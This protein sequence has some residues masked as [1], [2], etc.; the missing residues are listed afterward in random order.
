MLYLDQV[1]LSD[2]ILNNINEFL[3]YFNLNNIDIII[4]NVNKKEYYWKQNNY[5]KSKSFPGN[6]VFRAWSIPAERKSIIFQDQA[7][8]ELSIFWLIIHEITHVKLQTEWFLLFN[9]INI[10]RNILLKELNYTIND[11][12]DKGM[13]DDNFRNSEPEEILC[14]R[15]A[16][17]IIGEVLDRNW[18]KNRINNIDNII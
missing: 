15:V 11:Y 12:L 13:R 7:E 8:T 6:D 3:N 17:A 1:E 2:G 10:E 5:L 9:V 16:N 18:W 14:D 4:A